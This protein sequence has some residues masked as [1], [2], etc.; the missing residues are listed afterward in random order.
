MSH[1]P[2]GLYG[3]ADATFGDPV[4]QA[5]RLVA[6]GC[7]VVQL[8]CKSWPMKD[9][10]H[11]AQASLRITRAGG[12]LLIINDDIRC[13]A[14]AGA[15]GVHLGQGDGPIGPARDALPPG[16]LVGRSTHDQHEIRSAIE[17]CA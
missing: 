12:A 13:A 3:M 1:L 6:A 15:D 11:A 7:R 8:R 16:A 14:E 10:L 2:P 4:T 17:E 5:G 9:R